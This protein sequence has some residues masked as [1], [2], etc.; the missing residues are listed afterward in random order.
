M[1]RNPFKQPQ[2]DPNRLV[3]NVNPVAISPG[4]YGAD[5]SFA[6][7]LAKVGGLLSNIADYGTRLAYNKSKQYSEALKSQGEAIALKQQ[8]ILKSGDIEKY[9]SALNTLNY[10]IDKANKPFRIDD[11]L[12]HSNYSPTIQG[13]S[14]GLSHMNASTRGMGVTAPRED[15]S[16]GSQLKQTAEQGIQ[17]D[18]DKQ[19]DQQKLDSLKQQQ[20]RIQSSVTTLQNIVGFVPRGTEAVQSYFD[21][22][23]PQQILNINNYATNLV[24][25][26]PN[27]SPSEFRQQ[28]YAYSTAQTKGML[29]LGAT[30]SVKK[31]NEAVDKVVADKEILLMK[32]QQAIMKA[33]TTTQVQN[34]ALQILSSTTTPNAK[35]IQPDGVAI[36]ITPTGEV[37]PAIQQFA[38]STFT[39]EYGEQRGNRKHPGIDVVLKGDKIQS[40]MNGTVTDVGFD[41]DGYGNYIKVKQGDGSSILYAHLATPPSLKKGGKVKAGDIIGIQGAT[42]NARGKHL[43]LETFDS[44]GNRVNPV[45]MI[46]MWADYKPTS[47]RAIGT[48]TGVASTNR[49]VTATPPEIQVLRNQSIVNELNTLMKSLGGEDGIKQ[50][51]NIIDSLMKKM[52]DEDIPP[53]RAYDILNQLIKTATNNVSTT[54]D[55]TG[56]ITN[57]LTASA[58]LQFKAEKGRTYLDSLELAKHRQR[59]A[60][61]EA[62]SEANIQGESTKYNM[63]LGLVNSGVPPGSAKDRV[64]SQYGKVAPSTM[65]NMNLE[66]AYR[67]RQTAQQ[68]SDKR[69]NISQQ[70]DREKLA[71]ADAKRVNN[72]VVKNLDEI[73]SIA[74][75]SQKLGRK[76]KSY[77]EYQNIITKAQEWTLKQ[78]IPVTVEQALLAVDGKPPSQSSTKQPNTPK[79]KP[80]PKSPTASNAIKTG[81]GKK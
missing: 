6:T 62:R 80:N 35:I 16:F 74:T 72:F 24:N 59:Q 7:N 36:K 13:R 27:M 43:H 58:L 46:Q 65:Q 67:N 9:Q 37:K 4:Q 18:L 5:T 3:S 19:A 60:L 1:E 71:R 44:K 34:N 12:P 33:V 75:L 20:Q 53:N 73:S 22:K 31:L 14:A 8:E 45:A 47:A 51:Q 23:A 39:S 77:N 40:V 79:P 50:S 55:D 10:E 66:I 78:D 21:T 54:P 32:N 69:Y 49:A 56:K 42:G 57:T 28:M 48:A 38:D 26:N 17:A 30:E 52:I 25:N 11:P 41:P 64:E 15:N 63:W 76:V 61:A 81:L 70:Q 68:E 29:D 2:Q